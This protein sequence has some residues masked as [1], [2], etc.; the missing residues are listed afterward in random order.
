MWLIHCLTIVFTNSR[1]TV[2][3]KKV[4]SNLYFTWAYIIIY[5]INAG[6]TSPEMLEDVQPYGNAGFERQNLFATNQAVSDQA[7]KMKPPRSM[8]DV[9]EN[10]PIKERRQVN[11]STHQSLRILRRERFA[12]PRAWHALR[13]ITRTL[14][15]PLLTQ[16]RH[17]AE[18]KAAL[19]VAEEKPI[20]CALTF[21]YL[22]FQEFQGC[23][24]AVALCYKL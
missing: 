14:S 5:T 16:A 4:V 17:P 13:P 2:G 15:G 11:W 10:E 3:K 9:N 12:L 22:F 8:W 6:H 19:C 20:C 24:R 7:L 23:R 1:L 21:I 18:G